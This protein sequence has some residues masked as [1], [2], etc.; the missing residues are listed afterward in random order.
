MDRIGI[1][2]VQEQISRRVSVTTRDLTREME[3]ETGIGSS[4]KDDEVENY[5]LEVLNELKSHE[6]QK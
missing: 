6:D 2:K 1:S 4:S 5:I 3:L